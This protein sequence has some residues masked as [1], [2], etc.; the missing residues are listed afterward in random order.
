MGS[1]VGGVLTIDFQGDWKND[2]PNIYTVTDVQNPF[3]VNNTWT[4]DGHTTLRSGG[5][6]HGGTSRTDITITLNSPGVFEY[7]ACVGSE[8]NC[9]KLWVYVDGVEKLQISGSV[10]F[11]VHTE[12]LAAGQHTISLRYTKDG[13]VV[14]YQDAGAFGYL[15]FTGIAQQKYLIK[16]EQNNLYDSSGTQIPTNVIEAQTF[17]DYGSDDLPVSSVL[18]AFTNPTVLA[19]NELDIVPVIQAHEVATP[20]PQIIYSGDYDMTD[21]SI[22]GIEDADIVASSDVLFAISTDQ[23]A[24]WKAHNGTTWITLS[25]VDSGM[26]AETFNSIGLSDWLTIFTGNSS[27]RIRAMIPTLT[28]YIES[29][30]INFI[31]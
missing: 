18:T 9:D 1:L 3:Y 23:G 14:R 4:Y 24:T 15:K 25:S 10:S 31:N 11:A 12:Q 17:Y 19:W 6:G 5:I 28:S 16:D 22:L 26:N 2:Y 13:S 29:V 20:F 7:N 30:I 21:P 27:F 8:D